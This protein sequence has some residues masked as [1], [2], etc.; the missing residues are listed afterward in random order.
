MEQEYWQKG[1]E[2]FKETYFKKHKRDFIELVKKGQHPKALFITCSDSRVVPNIITSTK[3]GELFVTRNVGNFVPPYKP[4]DDYHATA[5]VIEYSIMH[6]EV[7]DIIICGHS[8]CGACKALYEDH[9]AHKED[10]IHTINWLKLGEPAKELALKSIPK[11]NKEQLFRATEKFSL[12]FQYQNLLTYPIVKRKMEEEK[13]QIH[14]WYYRIDKGEV[15]YY[16]Y[17]DK[18]FYPI[19]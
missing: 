2:T 4:D 7:E 13:L 9:S 8:D 11:E 12:L 3:P 6:L 1:I 15:R 14:L 19:V 10:M 17:E 16:D 5:S 18:K